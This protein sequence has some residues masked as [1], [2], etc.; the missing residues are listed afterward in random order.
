MD[1]FAS[2]AF[3]TALARDYH[4][5]S[6]YAFRTYAIKGQQVRLVEIDGGRPITDGPF[7]DYVKPFPTGGP[8]QGTVSYLPRLVTSVIALQDR[9][10]ES[11]LPLF[12]QEPAPLILWER[13]STWEDY[14]A[15]LGGRSKNNSTAR[16]RK[17]RRMTEAFGDPVFTFD[18]RD[19]AALDSCIGWKIGQYEGGHETLEDPRALLMLKAM[20][21]DGHLI[22]STLRLEGRCVAVDT[23]FVWQGDFLD[24]VSAYDP[25]FAVNGVGTELRMRLLEHS[26]RLG[27]RSFD[28]L[29]GTE[30]YKWYYATH[31]Q[32]VESYGTPPLARRVRDTAQRA[33]KQRLMA[34]SPQLF[35]RAKRLVLGARR[36]W[37]QLRNRRQQDTTS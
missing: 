20:H 32:L 25:A 9:D 13:F 30:S 28:L 34:L 29:L 31:L 12:A 15:L 6:T 10:P 35:Y 11:S 36:R 5:A 18:D 17:L 1:F 4:G 14:L 8:S 19:P 37:A 2:D 23:G 24:V 21:R 33:V 27:H 3:L 16:R 22:V 26:Y 7:Y